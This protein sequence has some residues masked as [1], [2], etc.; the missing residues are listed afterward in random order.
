[1]A[2]VCF[3]FLW[4]IFFV[5]AAVSDRVEMESWQLRNVENLCE[6]FRRSTSAT[7]KWTGSNPR[8][9]PNPRRQ[10]R[11]WVQMTRTNLPTHC[12]HKNPTQEVEA[13][14]SRQPI[15]GRG[16]SDWPCSPLYLLLFF[17]HFCCRK[18]YR[19]VGHDWQAS[20]CS[21]TSEI[22]PAIQVC[23]SKMAADS[24]AFRR[25]ATDSGRNQIGF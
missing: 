18:S 2:F 10:T 6:D 7:D 12:Q 21:G 24:V 3:F 25:L 13:G 5:A 22:V 15:S 23:V 20:Q 4:N 16:A 19:L 11:R 8:A 17:V 9:E 1:M 14:S